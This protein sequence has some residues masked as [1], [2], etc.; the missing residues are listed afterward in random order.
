MHFCLGCLN[1]HQKSN[2]FKIWLQVLLSIIVVVV[3]PFVLSN[4]VPTSL[5]KY[6][7]NSVYKQYSKNTTY[8]VAKVQKVL[9]ETYITDE[10]TRN[11]MTTQRLQLVI[12]SSVG[13][14][15]I[16]EQLA[17][18]DTTDSKQKYNVGETVV[19]R[20]DPKTGG[21]ETGRYYFILDKYRVGN[22]WIVAIVFVLLVILLSGA[23]GLSSV[24]GLIFSVIV[25][26]QII[27]PGVLSGADILPLTMWTSLL[28][29]TFTLYLG[30]GFNRKT[31]ICLFASLITIGISTLLAIGVVDF[32]S[33][34]GYGNEDVFHL[35]TSGV[36]GNI[37]LRG[38]LLS[39][40][41]IGSIGVLDDA[42]T[43]QA[44]A[45]EEISK[46]NPRL[47]K[48]EL[49]WRGMRIGKEHV[50]SLV[51][52]LAI[53]YV[54]SSMPVLLSFAAFNFSP[55]W[56]M[57]N[58]QVIAEEIVRSIVGSGCLLLAIPIANALSAVF[59]KQKFTSEKPAFSFADSV[60]K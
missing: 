48:W 32:T 19:L 49:F 59:L 24:F 25:I 14:G 46:A 12:E 37:N 4:F 15:E 27:I 13:K 23:K 3:S 26:I 52:T 28:I 9:D 43:A 55:I 60:K 8:Q 58:D 20:S 17:Q 53:A 29:L 47:T 51:N 30:H 38:L 33:L 39:G 2:P 31:T 10:L 57:I 22:I 11:T 6:R 42:T 56:V 36:T 50:V 34:S 16:I 40:M 41:I 45:I 54:G 5:S 44:V 21:Q 18:T 35:K 7:D 1:D